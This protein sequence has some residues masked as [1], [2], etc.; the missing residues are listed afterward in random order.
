MSSIHISRRF[1]P[2]KRGER[3]SMSKARRRQ[4]INSLYSGAAYSIC[5]VAQQQ[6]LYI[7]AVARGSS[8][9]P[10]STRSSC[11]YAMGK[12]KTVRVTDMD[13][14]AFKQIV[15]RRFSDI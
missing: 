7:C 10:L 11:V 1:W 6:Q 15:D 4:E 14:A 8:K 13:K 3:K 9:N 12:V 2:K 5:G